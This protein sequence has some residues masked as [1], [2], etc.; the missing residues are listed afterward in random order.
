M[1][2]VSEDVMSV[3]TERIEERFQMPLADLRR[4]VEK[5]PQANPEA[6]ALVHWHGLLTETQQALDTAEDALVEALGT[7][8]ADVLDDPVMELAHQVNSAV[9]S[10]DGRAMVVNYLLDPNA[11]GKRGPGVWRGASP[12]A[13]R[14]PALPTSPPT[15]PIAR[16]TTARGAR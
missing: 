8:P 3:L 16:N 9:A 2:D 1:P 15:L 6:T 4:A 7:Q 12:A 11:P 10:R 13:R 5:A 14:A